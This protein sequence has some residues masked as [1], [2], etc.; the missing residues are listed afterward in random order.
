MPNPEGKAPRSG[1]K[2]TV[3]IQNKQMQTNIQHAAGDPLV[4]AEVLLEQVQKLSALNR[5][6]FAF[7]IA[8][9]VHAFSRFCH[10]R[11]LFP[12]VSEVR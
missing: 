9:I 2:T 8:T 12:E 11:Y 3:G 6:Q 10:F 5:K 1:F 7:N 4:L